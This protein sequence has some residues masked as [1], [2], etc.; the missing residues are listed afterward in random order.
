MLANAATAV[1]AS[2]RR[3]EE[4]VEVIRAA[5][6]RGNLPDHRGVAV[7]RPSEVGCRSPGR[8]VRRVVLAGGLRPSLDRELAH[9]RRGRDGRGRCEELA[10]GEA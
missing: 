5:D 6:G 2:R 10:T 8:A 1:R 4:R 9:E 3:I 7:R